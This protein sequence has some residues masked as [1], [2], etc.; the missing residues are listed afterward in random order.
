MGVRARNFWILCWL[1]VEAGLVAASAASQTRTFT[2]DEIRLRDPFILADESTQ[3]YYLVTSSI[4]PDGMA[5]P[6]G[7]ARTRIRT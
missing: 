7:T 3:T 5:G 6:S 1:I 2:L 4:K